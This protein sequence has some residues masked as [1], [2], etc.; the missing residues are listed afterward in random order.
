[1]PPPRRNRRF[2]PKIP[3]APQHILSWHAHDLPHR[4]VRAAGRSGTLPFGMTAPPHIE[5]GPADQPFDFCTAVR[6]L[7]ATISKQS[8]SFRHIDVS[9]MLFTVSQARNG[10]VH[11]LQA[12]VTPMRFAGGKMTHRLH[13]AEY[14]VQRFRYDGHEILYVMSFCLP[15]FLNQDFDEKVVT[16]FHELYHISP[17]FDGDLRRH[18]GRYQVHTHSQKHYDDQMSHFARDYLRSAT[19]PGA[20]AF[21]RLNFAQLRHRHGSIIGVTLPRPKLIPVVSPT[22]PIEFKESTERA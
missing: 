22:Q 4:E 6:H 21:L 13:G 18:G 14:M 3:K 2:L 15:R 20:H 19:D 9:R 8:E 1:M 10:R 11:G 7:C 17:S 12:R 16:L 5:T